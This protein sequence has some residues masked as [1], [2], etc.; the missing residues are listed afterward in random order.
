MSTYYSSTIITRRR[1]RKNEQKDNC[2]EC[3]TYKNSTS[4]RSTA[5]AMLRT[6]NEDGRSL[7]FG[8]V[9]ERLL[10]IRRFL[11]N[12]PTD[13]TITSCRNYRTHQPT[14]LLPLA[15]YI[16]ENRKR[17]KWKAMGKQNTLSVTPYRSVISVW[18][19]NRPNGFFQQLP[20]LVGHEW[21]SH[22]HAIRELH[23]LMPSVAEHDRLKND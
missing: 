4:G 21:K 1:W 18:D 9:A 12:L 15:T 8:D 10:W 17:E 2:Q 6:R 3:E 16:N 14:W 5:D 13:N 19:K 7:F 23:A 22:S 11:L 20:R